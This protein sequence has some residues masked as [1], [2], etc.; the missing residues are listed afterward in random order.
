MHRE[1]I[2]FLELVAMLSDVYK[3]PTFILLL[4]VLDLL[5]QKS[6]SKSI[7]VVINNSKLLTPFKLLELLNPRPT[8]MIANLSLTREK[9]LSM[10]LLAFLQVCNVCSKTVFF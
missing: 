9:L 1:N 6:F 7:V 3:W 4:S 2:A 5:P 8:L 10:N